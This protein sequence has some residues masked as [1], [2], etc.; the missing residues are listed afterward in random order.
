[1]TVLLVCGPPGPIA[2]HSPEVCY[3]GAGYDPEAFPVSSNLDYG[4]AGKSARLLEGIYR[5]KSATG[6]EALRV[7]WSFLAHDIWDSP[8]NPRLAY[9][10]ERA[11]Y[12]LY[13]I[14]DLSSTDETRAQATAKDFTR[15]LLAALDVSLSQP[16]GASSSMKTTRKL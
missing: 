16:D 10:P 14:Q 8:P 1:M 11:L 4:A 3:R 9:A 5:K 15:Q 2:V 6:P 13:V 7:C 12:K